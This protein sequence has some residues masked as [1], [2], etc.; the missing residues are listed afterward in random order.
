VNEDREI[1][2]D[3]EPRDNPKR[4][5]RW[6]RLNFPAPVDGVEAIIPAAVWD[7]YH[8]TRTAA[9]IAEA[10]L[11]RRV[12]HAK[13]LIVDGRHVATRVIRHATDA[14]F[15]SDFFRR[16]RGQLT[17]AERIAAAETEAGHLRA[18]MGDDWADGMYG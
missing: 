10:E 17:R 6:L 11:R 7:N 18:V 12:G 15:T 8:A 1:D 5:L 4:D 2:W 14:S 16:T 3:A 9:D 13:H